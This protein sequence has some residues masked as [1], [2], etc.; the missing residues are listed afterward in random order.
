MNG[1]TSADNRTNL[2][3]VIA[4]CEN[5]VDC[6]RVLQLQVRFKFGPMEGRRKEKKGRRIVQFPRLQLIFIIII[7]F[8]YFGETFDANLC[9]KTCDNCNQCGERISK[10]VT[11][12]AKNFT[13]IIKA[14]GNGTLTLKQCLDIP[15]LFPLLLLL[16]SFSQK[17]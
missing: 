12:D 2:N 5:I 1:S 9:D 13:Q 10:D 6:R 4:Y 8:Q 17:S 16:F 7:S 3:R 15:F 14:V 11:A